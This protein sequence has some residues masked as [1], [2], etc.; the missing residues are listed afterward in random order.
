VFSK[1]TEEKKKARATHHNLEG[2]FS[3]GSFKA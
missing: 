2:A 3:S 1:K